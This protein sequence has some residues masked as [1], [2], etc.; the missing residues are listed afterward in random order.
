MSKEKVETF[1]KSWLEEIAK[2]EKRAIDSHGVYLIYLQF[3]RDI[4]ILK[5]GLRREKEFSHDV[6]LELNMI[7][8]KL[9]IALET[10]RSK[11]RLQNRTLWARIIEGIGGIIYKIPK[12]VIAESKEQN[13]SSFSS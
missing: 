9:S 3:V 12:K 8:S 5:M 10:A 4:S 6:L 1:K 11:Y 13:S 2:I 7:E